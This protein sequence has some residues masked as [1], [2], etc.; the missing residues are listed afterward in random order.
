[1]LRPQSASSTWRSV[2]VGRDPIPRS[3]CQEPANQMYDSGGS[4]IEA[5]CLPHN[6]PAGRKRTV[7]ERHALA[8]GT[9]AEQWGAYLGCEFPCLSVTG[10][11]EHEW[12]RRVRVAKMDGEK[13]A[14]VQPTHTPVLHRERLQVRRS[15]AE[16]F[17]VGVDPLCVLGSGVRRTQTWGALWSGART[18]DRERRRPPSPHPGAGCHTR[19]RSGGDRDRPDAA[20]GRGVGLPPPPGAHAGAG[21]RV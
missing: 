17:G 3:R 2:L 7:S 13:H 8:H 20:G 1:M 5:P 19:S 4:R 12:L 21:T 6:A 9:G 15:K 16:H 11:S 14:Y 18:R 10:S